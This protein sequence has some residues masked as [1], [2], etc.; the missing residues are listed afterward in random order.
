MKTFPF[1]M[2]S[3]LFLRSRTKQT[4]VNEKLG[5]SKKARRDYCTYL[6]Q[7]LIITIRN[8]NWSKGAGAR[9]CDP[10]DETG[11]LVLT[12]RIDGGVVFIDGAP[13]GVVGSKIPYTAPFLG[14]GYHF[15]EVRKPGMA[16]WGEV[17]EIKPR[18]SIKRKVRLKKARPGLGRLNWIPCRVLFYS[19]M[20]SVTKLTFRHHVSIFAT[21]WSID[22]V[23]RQGMHC[24]RA[25][26]C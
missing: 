9:S 10:T 13:V 23:A 26:R 7:C 17:V 4:V 2:D 8:L 21:C 14:I 19:G 25:G 16:R 1:S 24:R 15:V 5:N 3:E 11:E 18:K 12:S 20:N 22:I 6:M